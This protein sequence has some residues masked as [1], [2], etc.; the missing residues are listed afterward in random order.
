[1]QKNA[2]RTDLVLAAV[3]VTAVVSI[4]LYLST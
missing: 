1:V 4:A 3:A 2:F